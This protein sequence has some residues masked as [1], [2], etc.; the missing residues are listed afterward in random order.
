MESKSNPKEKV[1]AHV[2]LFDRSSN[3]VL[4]HQRDE[5]TVFDPN[6][7]AFFGGG[8]ESNETP[9]DCAIR[10]LEEETNIRVNKKELMPLTNYFNDNTK[11]HRYVFFVEKY[12]SKSDINLTEGKDC[13]WIALE[14]VFDYNL[15]EKT[16]RDLKTFLQK[17]E[18]I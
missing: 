3:A 10:E 7:W 13:D 5:N 15:T 18:N 8:C 4:L 6:K 2:F 17:R 12:I 9:E 14:K 16:E 11:A 1:S